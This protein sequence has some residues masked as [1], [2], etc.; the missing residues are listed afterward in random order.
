MP[1][2]RQTASVIEMSLELTNGRN[3]AIIHVV[4][5]GANDGVAAFD[6]G[7]QIIH[8]EIEQVCFDEG[9]LGFRC[10]TSRHTLGC[11]DNCAHVMASSEQLLD[12]ELADISG[13]T[14]NKDAHHVLYRNK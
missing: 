14:K 1:V 5:Q 8:A 9:Q 6:M 10:K 7:R 3:A 13:S 11:P 12:N 4:S 2:D